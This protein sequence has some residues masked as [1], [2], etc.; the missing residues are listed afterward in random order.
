[1]RSR[2]LR[3]GHTTRKSVVKL[4]VRPAA[5]QL[6]KAASLPIGWLRR[7]GLIPVASAASY[8]IVITWAHFCYEL[9]G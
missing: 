1:M 2:F 8:R 5:T 4:P 9:W 7:C 6:A 3:Y